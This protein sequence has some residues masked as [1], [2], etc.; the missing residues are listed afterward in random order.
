[1]DTGQSISLPALSGNNRMRVL[2]VTQYFWPESFRIN[3]LV[4]ALHKEGAEITVLTGQPNYPEGKL[5]KGY[6]IFSIKT[7]M[8][9]GCQVIRVPIV[10]RGKAGAFR[11]IVNYLSFMIPEVFSVL[12]C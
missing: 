9:N 3:E 10:P 7:E 5:F 12:G 8:Y 1:M 4:D 2:L 6:R 11:L